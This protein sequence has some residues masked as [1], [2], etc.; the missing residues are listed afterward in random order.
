MRKYKCNKK[1]AKPMLPSHVSAVDTCLK[2]FVPSVP[3]CLP[4]TLAH[5][6][7]KQSF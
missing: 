4:L 2:F 7:T 1:T 3:A 6:V 5:N